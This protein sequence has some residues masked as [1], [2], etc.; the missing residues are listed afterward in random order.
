MH[1]ISN[2]TYLYQNHVVVKGVLSVLD[3]IRMSL[4]M[5]AIKYTEASD[6]FS[7]AILHDVIF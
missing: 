5:S 3:V 2:S 7:L 6:F 4:Q 1:E